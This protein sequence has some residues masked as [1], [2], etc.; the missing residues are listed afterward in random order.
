MF[1]AGKSKSDILILSLHWH[2]PYHSTG[3]TWV[4]ELFSSQSWG[5]PETQCDEMEELFRHCTRE[6]IPPESGKSWIRF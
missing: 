4:P 5:C 2:S 3:T 6:M 1:A